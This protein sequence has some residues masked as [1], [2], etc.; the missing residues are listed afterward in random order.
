[1]S[2]DSEILMQELVRGAH[3]DL[4]GQRRKGQ[5]LE[6]V[7]G[8]NACDCGGRKPGDLSMLMGRLWFYLAGRSRA[9]SGLVKPRAEELGTELLSYSS[10]AQSWSRDPL[11]GW[12]LC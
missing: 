11:W 4:H 1:M 2:E 12:D 7:T 9:P 6:R 8:R 5:Y 10:G 3:L